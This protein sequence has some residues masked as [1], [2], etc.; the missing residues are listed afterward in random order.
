MVATMTG[1]DKL[2]AILQLIETRVMPPGG[3]EPQVRVGFLENARYPASEGGQ[4]VASIAALQEFGGTI[5][6][7]PGTTTI[8]RKVNSA[9]TEFLRSGRFVKR[10]ESNFASDHATPA[11]SIRIPPRPFFRRMIKKYSPNWGQ[12]M[13]AILK[14]TQYDAARTL[15]LMGERIVRQLRQSIIDLTDPPL[16]AS[17]IARKSRG[18]KVTAR[19]VLGPAKPLVDTGHMLNSV[20]YE[21]SNPSRTPGSSGGIIHKYGGSIGST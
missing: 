6:R 17:T 7:P 21:I 18:G 8:Y 1:G 20:D 16:A 15:V 5:N 3:G 13:G 4:H 9:R 12:D 19:G 14:F 11:Y 10:R 2:L